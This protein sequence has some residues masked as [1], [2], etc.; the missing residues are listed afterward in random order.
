MASPQISLYH[1]AIISFD[2]YIAI[3]K[4]LHYTIVIT[5]RRLAA[6]ITTAW[7]VSIFVSILPLLGWNNLHLLQEQGIKHFRLCIN[8]LILHQLYKIFVTVL[9]FTILLA[10]IFMNIHVL[11]I[12]HRLS[13]VSNTH[14]I[15]GSSNNT[16]ATPGSQQTESRKG[17]WVIITMV[18]LLTV[19]WALLLID[20]IIKTTESYGFSVGILLYVYAIINPLLYGLGNKA[21][22]QHM[23]CTCLWGYG[24]FKMETPVHLNTC[25]LHIC[26][27]I[28]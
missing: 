3:T 19:C 25:W 12:A 8:E 27:Y 7:S 6:A 20:F 16:T 24:L 21:V 14:A 11:T 28:L 17:L 22:R 4:P 9:I 1:L 10:V 23:V 15:H 5:K 13:R 2:W 26:H 18:I